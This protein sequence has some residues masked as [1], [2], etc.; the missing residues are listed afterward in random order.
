M[1]AFDAQNQH[2]K[3]GV[4]THA[5]YLTSEDKAWER[6]LSSTLLCTHTQI[7]GREGELQGDV[8]LILRSCQLGMERNSQTQLI[9]TP[10]MIWYQLALFED[11]VNFRVMETCLS[12]LFLPLYFSLCE[13]LY[14]L[15]IGNAERMLETL[16]FIGRTGDTRAALEPCG[17]LPSPVQETRVLPSEFMSMFYVDFWSCVVLHEEILNFTGDLFRLQIR[18]KLSGRQGK[19]FTL[20]VGSH[21]IISGPLILSLR[22]HS[23]L[24]SCAA[25]GVSSQSF[26][27]MAEALVCLRFRY[28]Q[29]QPMQLNWTVLGGWW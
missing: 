17:L 12:G 29:P 2:K 9:V 8:L 22:T 27:S 25:P 28:C 13:L 7:L 20:C 6:P 1:W 4:V 19:E 24:D 14:W 5:Y 3:L 16:G 26:S 21:L 11:D 18:Q 23:L 10:Q 15:R